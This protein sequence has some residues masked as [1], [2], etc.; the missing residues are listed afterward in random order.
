M[1]HNW[2]SRSYLGAF[3]QRP[4]HRS[5][6][7]VVF[8]SLLSNVVETIPSVL[9]SLL[10]VQI[11]HQQHYFS[12]TEPIV[13]MLAEH[14]CPPLFFKITF[15]MQ[16][17]TFVG[18]KSNCM[19]R[20]YIS[21]NRQP[22]HCRILLEVCTSARK[23]KH[24]CN[25]FSEDGKTCVSGCDHDIKANTSASTMETKKKYLK[26]YTERQTVVKVRYVGSNSKFSGTLD[27]V[28]DLGNKHWRSGKGAMGV[29]TE[30]RCMLLAVASYMT[31]KQKSSMCVLFASNIS[32]GTT[33]P[34]AVRAME[35][36]GQPMFPSAL[37]SMQDAK[38]M[39]GLKATPCME[40]KHEEPP[41]SQKKQN[42][43]KR[44]GH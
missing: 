18:A 12:S 3:F 23:Q 36:V 22:K 43:K 21:G 35:D 38:R 14:H 27:A 1:S 25:K 40:H 39:Y 2:R 37:Q 29:V 13:L 28:Q 4:P 32:A 6:G 20:K 9:V 7:W 30:G 19:V 34:P 5:F 44:S 24:C 8:C 33:L 11:S 31:K 16:P 41:P 10:H 15:N 17:T 42:A 26:W